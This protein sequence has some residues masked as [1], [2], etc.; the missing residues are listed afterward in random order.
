MSLTDQQRDAMIHRHRQKL[1]AD[2]KLSPQGRI[3]Q[4]NCFIRQLEAEYPPA[5]DQTPATP[6][7]GT[8]ER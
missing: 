4:L 3:H 2:K 7:D 5:A 1:L 8:L 6:E